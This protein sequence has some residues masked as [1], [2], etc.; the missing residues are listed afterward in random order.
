MCNAL[1]ECGIQ[2]IIKFILNS[3]LLYIYIHTYIKTILRRVDERA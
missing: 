3:N 1:S 2:I